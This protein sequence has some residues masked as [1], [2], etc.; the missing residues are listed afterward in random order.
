MSIIYLEKPDI[1]T[2]RRIRRQAD[3]VRR[4]QQASK[5]ARVKRNCARALL[6]IG[7]FSA[8]LVAYFVVWEAIHHGL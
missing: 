4:Y 7:L 8:A 5:M 2:I 3:V 1:A 6:L